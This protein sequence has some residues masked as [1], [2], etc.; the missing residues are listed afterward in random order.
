L[1][2]QPISKPVHLE[3]GALDVHSYFYTIQGEGPFTGKPALFV[4][5]WGCNLQC[6]GC[7]TEYTEKRKQYSPTKLAELVLNKLHPSAIVVITGGEPLRQNLTPFLEIL[8]KKGRTVQIETNGTLPL[9]PGLEKYVHTGNPY[10]WKLH[11][12]CSPKTGK[13]N[14]DLRPFIGAY[15]YVGSKADLNPEDGLPLTALGH[16]ASPFV[17]RPHSFFAG[18]IYLQPMDAHEQNS[19]AE[20]LDACVRSVMQNGYTLQLQTHKLIGAE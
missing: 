5:L 13:V 6:P 7:D 12:V 9:S 11:V 19:N 2:K 8:L 1:N 20:N 3:D 17:A 10:G 18:P 14:K 16:S 4:R 15:K